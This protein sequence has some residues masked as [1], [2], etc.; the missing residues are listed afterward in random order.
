MKG[1]SRE[2]FPKNCLGELSNSSSQRL[3]HD[4]FRKITQQ[5][6]LEGSPIYLP[7]LGSTFSR[8]KTFCF[9]NCVFIT[10][11]LGMCERVGEDS[12]HG[13]WACRQSSR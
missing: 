6:A 4:C 9:E 11:G 13:I 12:R 2:D 3:T 5:F 7:K 1:I 8:T 10:L